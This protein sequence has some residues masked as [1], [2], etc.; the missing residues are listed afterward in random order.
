[1]VPAPNNLFAPSIS[2]VNVSTTNLRA[3]NVDTT[4]I[5]GAPYPPAQA[6]FS[7]TTGNF[8]VPAPNNLIAPNISTTNLRATGSLET[9]ALVATNGSIGGVTIGPAGGINGGAITGTSL[10]VTNVNTTTINNAAYPPIQPQFSTTTGNFIIPDPYILIVDNLISAKDINLGVSGVLS[11]NRVAVTTGNIQIFDS[12]F[13]TFGSG[14][15]NFKFGTLNANDNCITNL[16]TTNMIGNLNS[17]KTITASNFI[18]SNADFSGL[19]TAGIIQTE[20]LFAS[21]I[22]CPVSEL[23]TIS[24]V[25]SINGL[26]YPPPAGGSAST[27]STFTVSSLTTNNM[28]S[29]ANISTGGTLFA[30]NATVVGQVQGNQVSGN[31]INGGTLTAATSITAGTTVTA[32]G[33]IR[34]GA[35]SSIGSLSGTTLTTTGGITAANAS[36]GGTTMNPGG[37]VNCTNLTVSGTLGLPG[38]ITVGGSL[39]VNSNIV[40]SNGSVRARQLISFTD[41]IGATL[42]ISNNALSINQTGT[43]ETAAGNYTTTNGD[44]TATNGNITGATLN[45]AGTLSAS[46]AEVSTI[47]A[48]R[49][50]TPRF[51]TTGAITAA[52]LTTLVNITSTDGDI[53]AP[54]GR[55]TFSN[56][57]ITRDAG[58]TRNLGVS[59]I[60]T[61]STL[62]G[63]SVN[64]STINAS[65]INVST[66]F[67]A[68][69]T[70]QNLNTVANAAPGTQQQLGSLTAFAPNR[71]TSYGA[72]N[73]AMIRAVGMT[74]NSGRFTIPSIAP[75]ASALILPLQFYYL[76]PAR[77]TLYM[78]TTD[79]DATVVGLFNLLALRQQDG[80]I[81][82]Q[83]VA[84][85]TLGLSMVNLFLNN[86]TT[87]GTSEVQNVSGTTITNLKCSWT[88][89]PLDT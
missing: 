62:N 12:Q 27:F 53:S 88:Y 67:C 26:P 4:T 11:G 57:T 66:L 35:I 82:I 42:N 37:N 78:V 14:I 50:T 68:S 45:T 84:V 60:T 9:G 44:I 58:V 74:Y 8:V 46:N 38:S 29:I 75:N 81:R 5:N 65:T 20:N 52:S 54:V 36:I 48:G 47:T 24:A 15:Y 30:A 61:I 17:E 40:A 34:G 76:T 25:S 13:A 51:D 10:A 77:V 87:I 19:H 39:T 22:I 83:Q 72:G 73:F 56:L 85:Y 71:A 31:F 7:T 1:V 69:E 2:T 49:L 63:R 18:G 28:R 59:G 89:Y 43:I 64:V 55:G 23:T 86:I 33:I 79:T 32:T 41:V 16:S 70:V 21:S 80:N 3:T 6:Q